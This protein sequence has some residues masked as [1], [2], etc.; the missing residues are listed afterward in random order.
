MTTY[1]DYYKRDEQSAFRL[2]AQGIEIQHAFCTDLISVP[3]NFYQE[4]CSVYGKDKNV[5]RVTADKLSEITIY[6]DPNTDQTLKAA[7]AQRIVMENISTLIGDEDRKLLSWFCQAITRGDIVMLAQLI[8]ALHESAP[9]K[10]PAFTKTLSQTFSDLGAGVIL[11]ASSAEQFLLHLYR[12]NCAIAIDSITKT[13][14]LVPIN[15]EWDGTVIVK[16]GEIV[17]PAVAEL[18][19]LISDQAV[20]R[21]LLKYETESAEGERL[22][23]SVVKEL[24]A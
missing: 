21:I 16:E 10:L 6:N 20:C 11:T 5:W 8:C 12:A 3:N 7:L 14:S 23:V 9:Q 24:A 4:P 18:S 22:P 1:T 15:T 13:V 19:Q 17:S 2:E